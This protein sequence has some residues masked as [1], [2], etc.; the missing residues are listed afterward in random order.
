MPSNIAR[1]LSLAALCLALTIPFAVVNHTYPIPT[2]YAEFSALALFLVVGGGMALIVCL[3]EPRV[4]FATPVIAL[5]PLVLGLLLVAQSVLLPV[6]QP[7]MNWLGGGYLLAAFMATHAGYG[8]TRAKLNETA[9]R[10]GAGALIVGGLFAV[11]CQ[12][13]QLF[14]LETRVSPLVVAYNVTVE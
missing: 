1:Y 9:L 10:W 12:V 13:I 14:H 11:F 5:M 8:F 2:F 4:P 7:S 3:S 6:S